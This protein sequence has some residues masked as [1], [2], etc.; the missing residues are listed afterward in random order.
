MKELNLEEKQKIALDILKE[1]KKICIENNLRFYLG[2]G[3]LLGAI[4]NEKIIPWDDDIDVIMPREDYM[5]LLEIFPEKSNYKILS[6]YNTKDY[7]RADLYSYQR[8]HGAGNT[9]RKSSLRRRNRSGRC[10]GGRYHCI[11]W[12]P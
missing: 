4:R 1:L 6:I 12:R 3:T 2:Y 10:P 8:Q 11:L 7:G 9:G 5:K